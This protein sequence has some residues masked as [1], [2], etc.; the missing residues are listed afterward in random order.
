MMLVPQGV[1]EDRQEGRAGA[2]AGQDRQRFIPAAG[3]RKLPGGATG[4]DRRFSRTVLA[5][6]VPTQG[7]A[8]SWSRTVRGDPERGE[9]GRDTSRPRAEERLKGACGRRLE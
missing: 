2:A 1:R 4:E 3:G 5:F 9:I 6:E 8:D 7:G